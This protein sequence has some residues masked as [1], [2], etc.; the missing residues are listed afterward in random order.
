MGIQLCKDRETA[1]KT[2]RSLVDSIFDYESELIEIKLDDISEGR[3]KRIV[4]GDNIWE[5]RE[6]NVI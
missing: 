3:T 6:L 2:L 5:I 1:L 4:Y